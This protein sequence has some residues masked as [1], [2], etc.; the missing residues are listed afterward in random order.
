VDNLL[1][2]KLNI[3]LSLRHSVL[4]ASLF[5]LC[6]RWMIYYSSKVNIQTPASPR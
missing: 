3:E 6:G 5:D 1:R 4:S 2:P